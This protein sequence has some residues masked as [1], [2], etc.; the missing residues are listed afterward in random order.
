MMM[1][2]VTT[3]FPHSDIPG[4]QVGCHLPEAY[5]RLRRPSSFIAVE[6]S[7]IRPSCSDIIC[8]NTLIDQ[9]MV[10][11]FLIAYNDQ[12]EHVTRTTNKVSDSDT[13][14]CCF[15]VLRCAG[16]ASYYFAYY[17]YSIVKYRDQH[18]WNCHDGS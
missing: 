13:L 10:Y 9:H 7:T 16:R 14:R 6:A 5:R 3:G 2:Y 12:D 11:R 4:S 15:A 1:T 17:P 18:H 8:H